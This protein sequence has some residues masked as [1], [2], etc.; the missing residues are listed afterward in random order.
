ML[1]FLAESKVVTLRPK[2]R[3]LR[4]PLPRFASVKAAYSRLFTLSPILRSTQWL[5]LSKMTT[6][7]ACSTRSRAV[8]QLTIPSSKSTMAQNWRGHPRALGKRRVLARAA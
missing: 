1:E 6:Y 8:D 7:T 4:D 3:S 2:S 5:I